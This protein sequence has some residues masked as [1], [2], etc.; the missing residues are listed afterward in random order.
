MGLS[1]SE[2]FARY[3]DTDKGTFHSYDEFYEELFKEKKKEHLGVLLEIGVRRG[4]SLMAWSDWFPG[5]WAI[6]GM[7]NGSEAGI[8][9]PPE[10]RK[11]IEVVYGDTTKPD[12]LFPFQSTI[13]D[14]I[15]DDGLHHPYSQVAAFSALYP[16]VGQGGYYVI[17]DV[18]D[19]GFAETIARMFGGNVE[20][21]RHV[22]NRHDDILVWW[23]KP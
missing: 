18:E 21:R 5:M 17:E 9:D 16:Y 1:L 10:D 3:E 23:K 22:K 6:V 15:I 2:C 13:Y 12:T 7:D 8:W 20:D 19:I 14:I 4:G 11:R